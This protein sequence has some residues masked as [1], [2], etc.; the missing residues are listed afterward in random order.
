MGQGNLTGIE[1]AKAISAAGLKIT[2]DIVVAGGSAGESGGIFS[3]FI[4]QLLQG[5][6]ANAASNTNAPATDESVPRT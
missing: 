4:A 1:V 5:N 6:R 2:P 3:A